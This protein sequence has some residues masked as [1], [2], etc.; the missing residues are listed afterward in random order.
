MQIA[1][2]IGALLI[3]WLV[4]RGLIKIFKTSV[5]TALKIAAIVLILQVIFG[6]APQEIWQTILNLPQL[7]QQFF[8][9]SN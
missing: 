3:T 2:L 4:F 5:G 6:I 7:I 9:P 8:D 1:L